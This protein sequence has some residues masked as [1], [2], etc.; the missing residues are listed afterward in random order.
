MML[1]PFLFAVSFMYVALKACQ[2]LNVVGRHYVLIGPVSL[3][4]AFCE[5]YGITA[6]VNSPDHKAFAALAIGLG[7]WAGCVFAMKIH[8]RIFKG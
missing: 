5:V 3:G 1:L 7:A 8:N 2:Q 4:M 6:Y